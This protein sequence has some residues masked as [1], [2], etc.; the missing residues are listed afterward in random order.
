LQFSTGTEAAD[1][2][3]YQ[4]RYGTRPK[5]VSLKQPGQEIQ[6]EGSATLVH[7]LMP[8][9]LIDEYKFLVHPIIRGAESAFS[10]MGWA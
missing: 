7:S 1:K 10:K 9:G 2:P 6:I 4:V 8:T 5:V 3:F